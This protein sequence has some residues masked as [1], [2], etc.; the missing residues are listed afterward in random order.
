MPDE[1]R[2]PESQWANQL[3][4]SLPKAIVIKHEHRQN[5]SVKKSSKP[6]T[7]DSFANLTLHQADVSV[8]TQKTA[9]N[10][11]K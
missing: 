2:L 8:C 6:Q 3:S 11:V 4:S 7:E 9:Y 1:E 10:K 5:N